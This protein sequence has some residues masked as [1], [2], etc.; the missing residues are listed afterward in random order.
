[1]RKK[2]SQ[3]VD[4]SSSELPLF[5]API[6]LSAEKSKSKGKALVGTKGANV[7]AKR[8]T[9]SVSLITGKT[10]SSEAVRVSVSA[11]PYA[12]SG[13]GESVTEGSSVSGADA[14]LG[15]APGNKVSQRAPPAAAGG[16]SRPALASP[17]GRLAKSASLENARDP[18]SAPPCASG[19]ALPVQEDPNRI[20]AVAHSP[21]AL[22]SMSG[23][24]R[25]DKLENLFQLL[26]QERAERVSVS[27]VTVS[28][29]A[30]TGSGSSVTV[31]GPGISGSGSAGAGT[32]SGSGVSVSGTDGRGNCASR[33]EDRLGSG[34]CDTDSYPS[35]G[36]VCASG[37]ASASGVPPPLEDTEDSVHG[38]SEGLYEEGNPL[39]ETPPPVLRR[40][41][42]LTPGADYLLQQAGPSREYG[43]DLA[44]DASVESEASLLLAGLKS[45]SAIDRK[46][47]EEVKVP[48][49]P[50][51]LGS[52][53]AATVMHRYAPNNLVPSWMNFH[54]NSLRGAK[55]LGADTWSPEVR[56]I[57]QWHPANL[58][59]Y[60]SCR[61]LFRL[62]RPL[63][64]DPALPFPAPPTDA[65][66]K[67]VPPHRRPKVSNPASAFISGS[68]VL[69]V[70][71]RMHTT[72]EALG[73]A[74]T[75]ASALSDAIRDP[76]D[77]DQLNENPNAEALLTTL[78]ALPAALSYAANS[79]SA[80]MISSNLS[81][82]EAILE[83]TDLPKD[84][85]LKLRVLPPSAGS[86]FGPLLESVRQGSQTRTPLS[87]EE[88]A[89]ALK[90]KPQEKKK[91]L[92]AS[93]WGS[94][95]K[96]RNQQQPA[97]GPPPAKRWKG[98]DRRGPPPQGRGRGRWSN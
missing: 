29:S 15:I 81:R 42:G 12:T 13:I 65:E 23:G 68:K 84:A 11:Q 57:E 21:D 72:A 28:G 73:V 32:S 83:K 82:R 20:H 24:N 37:S 48:S 17:T 66:A 40:E 2:R 26:L 49:K 97:S 85:L 71:Q 19:K 50:G 80:A 69:A 93:G 75:L 7:H 3:S 25:L 63:T 96:P 55:D 35:S 27:G 5:S 52:S 47:V 61:K 31:S 54:W 9:S 78:D 58:G 33:Y 91:N 64:L 39:C 10:V 16:E 67:L 6:I 89:R 43:L 77:R 14:P 46:Y 4:K 59:F 92:P 79:L 90:A 88:L 41:F 51:C 94:K 98:N 86:L 30:I 34:S 45:V 22:S 95:R 87:V 18:P 8:S 70:E 60:A 76:S 1:M 38:D 53:S 36:M 62:H 44:E 56:P 74:S